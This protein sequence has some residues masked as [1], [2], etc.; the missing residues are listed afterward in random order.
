MKTIK[1]KVEDSIYENVMF[2]LKSLKPNG[3]E[4]VESNNKEII[5][6]KSFDAKD[7]FGVAN[8]SKQEID[9]YLD[10]IRREWK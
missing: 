5:K 6:H 4:I 9:D 3:L 7:Y 1:L 8:S 10:K 2:L